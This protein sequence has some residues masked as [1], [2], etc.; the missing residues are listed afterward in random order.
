MINLIGTYECK[1][2]AKGRMMFSSAFK[3]QLSAVLQDG[4][5]LKRAV[6]QPCLE[7]YPMS[8]WQLMMAKINKLNRFVKRNNDFIRRFTAGVKLVELDASGRIL[9]PKDLCQFAGIQKE[10]VLSS[11]V[12]I[13]EV[14]DKEK[15]EK[16]IDE[17]A[18]DFADLAEE[19]MGNIEADELS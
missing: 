13:I 6:F 5:V 14:W 11:S 16:V 19:V 18:L 17:A 4:F 7:L 10:I 15:Y 8:E 2:D 9:I 12:N 1:I 3:K